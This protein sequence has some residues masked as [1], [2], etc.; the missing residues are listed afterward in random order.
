MGELS[1][2]YVRR[3][4]SYG[5]LTHMAHYAVAFTLGRSVSR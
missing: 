4:P 3:V 2:E 5:T 1:C